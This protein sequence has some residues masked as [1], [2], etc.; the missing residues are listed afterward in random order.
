MK[1][2]KTPI[3]DVVQKTINLPEK[4]RGCHIITKNIIQSLPE[5]K[6]FNC[7]TLNLFL[8]HTSAS[9][10]INENCCSDVR[11]DLENWMNKTVP[12]GKFWEHSSEGP[13]DMPAHVKSSLMGVSLDIPI[14]NGQ[15]QLGRWQ[16]IYL[17]EH[18]GYGGSRRMVLTITGMRK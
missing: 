6:E 18:R 3:F 13:D 2:A 14:T 4:P 11:T 1:A 8:Q 5:L 16:G 10:T 9:I 7:G 12:E 17:N 15:L